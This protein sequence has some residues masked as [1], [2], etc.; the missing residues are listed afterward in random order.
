MP[1]LFLTL[2][3]LLALVLP[4]APA[5]AQESSTKK[6]LS[7]DD[8][9]RW[10]SINGPA[11][12]SDGRWVAYGHSKTN[13]L[14]ADADTRLVL[15][16]VAAGTDVTI[17]DGSNARFSADGKWVAYTVT[18]RR[19]PPAAARGTDTTAGAAPAAGA[20]GRGAGA[21]ATP[22]PPRVELR[23]LA[24][25]AVRSWRDIQSAEFSPT[26]SH[27]ILRRRP[28]ATGAAAGAA[29]AGG[30]GRGGAGGGSSAAGGSDVILHELA[31]GRSILLGSVGETAFN[32][33]GD[34]LAYT[35]DAPVR[36]ANGL[37]LVT[38]AT[39]AMRALDN[40]T[41]RYARLTWDH[42]GTAL[43][44]LKGHAVTGKRER[45]NQLIVF[46]T[47][48]GSAAPVRLDP[49][50]VA[51]FPAGFELSERASLD[52]SED[53]QRVFLSVIPQKA[54][55]DTA[56]RPGTDS[57][58]DVD[59]WRSADERIQSQ[60]MVQAES[61]RNRTFRAVFDVGTARFVALADSS[62]R[63]VTI[64]TAGDYAVGYDPRA[65]ISDWKRPAAD[66]YRVD[67]RTG[68]RSKLLDA[69][70]T[71]AHVGGI[72]PDGRYFLY[73]RDARWHAIE[74][75]TATARPLGTGAPSFVN[76]EFDYTFTKPSYGIGGFTTDGSAA[77]I[78]T[79]FDLWVVPL[80]GG[81]A[82]NLTNGVGTREQIVL[83]PVRLAPVDSTT[84]PG[85]RARREW[86][87]SQPLT[88][89]AYGEWTKKSGYYR[90]ADG[91][92]TPLLYEDAS[93]GIATVADKAD[94]LVFTRQTF[95]EY[96]D[97][98][99][100]ST[101]FTNAT[102]ISEVN[103]QQAE[104]RWG[105][106][107]LF[108]YTTRRGVKLQ[109]VLALP[110]DYVA[111]T[112]LPMLVT[113]YEKNSQTMH[114]YP[115]P[116]FLTG[117]GGMPVEAVS[118]GYATML[119]DVH[120]HTGSSHSDMLD[121]VEAATRK[122]ISLGY[123]DPKRIGVHGH[124]YGGE[125]AAFIGVK[126]TLFAA[127]G[128]GAGVTDL[129]SDF[130]QSWGWTYQVTDGS[131]ANG[132]GYYMTGQGRWGFSPWDNPERYRNESALPFAHQAKAPILIMHGT[133]DPT[134]SFTEG[135]NFY[136]ALRF[137]GKDAVMLAYP[138]EG[139]GLRGLANRRDL[140]TRYFQFFD[141]YLRGAPAPKWMAEGVPYLVKNEVKTPE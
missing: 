90:L 45:A 18:P 126:S 73:W 49:R 35:V 115:T 88:L 99:V 32:V 133:A 9:A 38:L 122:V 30:G 10:R 70:Q 114:R 47:A 52:W 26:A 46:P 54:A 109:G 72:S 127:V 5:A 21:N 94:R 68:A 138:G 64:S 34:L 20:G 85:D 123:V 59:I 50:S 55:P 140:T 139:H 62:M 17:E 80:D 69:Q 27:L 14:P 89:S 41:L 81:R 136:N 65:Y 6:V 78:P 4:A 39:G 95:Q 76:T 43:A 71:G 56:R 86:D 116:S 79:R 40:D 67:L 58:A 22:A 135:M 100:A 63:D 131:G 16:D 29:P 106:R 110:D 107:V 37:Y 129:A 87:L 66:V 101:D 121:A 92:L 24:T 23:E 12:Y 130:S 141:H 125:G 1:R 28:A 61:D 119:P 83:R 111:G 19:R 102:R 33:G 2:L 96:P 11:M 51:D 84:R 57:L 134:V 128:M 120:F 15:R 117:M 91:A 97:L 124:S 42:R 113:F 103:P 3:S 98:R 13:V 75:A 44:A 93:I 31:S 25:G 60:Q 105:K 48:A 82:R 36:D 104:Y 53:G 8:Y 108:D 112:K 118:R 77:I 132:N 7:V 74:L 137:N